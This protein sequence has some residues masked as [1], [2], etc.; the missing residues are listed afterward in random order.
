M[1]VPRHW[2]LRKQRYRLEGIKKVDQQQGIGL[3]HMTSP[4]EVIQAVL[5]NIAW[6]KKAKEQEDEA[7]LKEVR[8]K[9][10]SSQ[11]EEG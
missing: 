4:P 6:Y 1:E 9:I 3:A 8:E 10:A 2:R 7:N 5:K 11:R